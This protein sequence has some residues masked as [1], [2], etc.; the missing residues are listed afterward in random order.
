MST[1]NL[2]P[3]FPAVRPA[4]FKTT[5]WSVVLSAQGKDSVDA[6]KSLELLCRQYWTP[7]YVFVRQSGHSEHDS[8]DLTQSFFAR[9]LEKNWLITADRERGRFRSFLL[10]ALKRFL[11]N[12]WD[13]TQARKRGGTAKIVSMDSASAILIPDLKQ[14]PPEASFD[15][16][17]ALALLD[18]VM[19]RLHD[20]YEAAG[21]IAEFDLLKP[22]LTAQRGSTDYESL[23]IA[24]K[25]QP[26]SARSSVHRLRKRFQGLFRE[27]IACTLADP[28]DI[29]DEMRAVIAALGSS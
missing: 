3:E 22:S 17:W 24:L 16:Q 4:S 25:I 14:M 19:R 10:T 8:Q 11:N 20:E 21:Q 2:S 27:E 5:R 7:L 18:V 9:L 12:E 15:R 23:A 6:T 28:A 13:R 1:T 26:T 29:D